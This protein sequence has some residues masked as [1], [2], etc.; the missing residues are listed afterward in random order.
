VLYLAADAATDAIARVEALGRSGDLSEAC[1]A[2]DSM[3]TEVNLLAE[4]LR[5]RFLATST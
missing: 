4:A 2:I 1:H 3:V 5:S